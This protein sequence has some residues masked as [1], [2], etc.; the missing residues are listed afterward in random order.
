MRKERINK[1]L[2]S[3]RSRGSLKKYLE[4]SS[5]DLHEAITIYERNMRL[6]EAFYSP[7]QCLEICL[8]NAMASQ[9]ASA[10][11]ENWPVNPDV[12]LHLDARKAVKEAKEKLPKDANQTNDIVAALSFGFWV[13]LLAKRYDAT[14]WREALF[15]AFLSSGKQKR[16]AVHER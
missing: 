6:S 11:G 2:E 15:R 9:M 12:P 4:Y 8:R 14:V 16:P 13:A 5:V 3:I 1:P 10:Y 7:L